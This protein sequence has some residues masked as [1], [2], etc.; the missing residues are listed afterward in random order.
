[1]HAFFHLQ[2]QL[3]TVAGMAPTATK[4]VEDTEEELIKAKTAEMRKKGADAAKEV[5]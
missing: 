5:E 3:L 2:L 1:M 4:E